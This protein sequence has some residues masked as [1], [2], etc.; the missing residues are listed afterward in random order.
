MVL[1]ISRAGEE[2]AGSWIIMDRDFHGN[3]VENYSVK[4]LHATRIPFTG[5]QVKQDPGVWIVWLG[6]A[7]IL[8]GIGLT[9]Y[10]SHRKLF[11]WAA[12]D[13]PGKEGLKIIIAGRT[14]RNEISFEQEFNRLCD[15]LQLEVG[16]KV[17]GSRP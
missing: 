15:R 1:L 4:V 6:F 7:A 17:G 3:K 13:A 9:Y 2:P 8:V 11:V 12:A 14:N 10:V 16:Q 5:L